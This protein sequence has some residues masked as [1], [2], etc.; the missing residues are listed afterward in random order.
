MN[1]DIE[2]RGLKNALLQAER[3]LVITHKKPDGDALGSS[4][5]LYEW[6]K[7]QNKN[8]KLFCR[9][10]PP[11]HYG[12]LNAYLDYTD[13][14]DVFNQEFDLVVVLDSGDLGYCGVA[15]LIPLL[16][17]KPKLLNIDHHPTNRLYGDVNLVITNA[18]STAEV[19]TR[20]F[21][22]NKIEINQAMATSLLTG[23]LTDTSHFS[24]AATSY[25]GM[26]IA[27]YLISRGARVN[28]ITKNLLKNKETNLLKLWGLAMSRLVKNSNYDVAATYLKLDDFERFGLQINDVEG[29]INF[30]NSVVGDAEMIV[31]LVDMGNQKI[32]GSFRSVKRDVSA[33]AKLIG[34]GGHKLAAGFTIDGSI[35]ETVAGFKII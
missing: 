10:L 5:G 9:D 32:K 3:I 21:I 31:L 17:N 14:T 35:K 25:D 6:L 1:K 19:I 30:L 28:E 11:A 8:V 23:I 22:A 20:F 34:G 33:I 15:E 26:N 12:Y 2:F 7:D 24:N 29:I 27:G 18:T 13:D 16:P 4:S